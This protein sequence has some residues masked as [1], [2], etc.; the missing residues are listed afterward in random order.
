MICSKNRCRGR[1]WLVQQWGVP[2]VEALQLQKPIASLM[3]EMGP[4]LGDL[5]WKEST[6]P[7]TE[8]RALPEEALSLLD[9]NQGCHEAQGA[10]MVWSAGTGMSS[11]VCRQSAGYEQEGT[12]AAV[13]NVQDWAQREAMQRKMGDSP[14]SGG[15]RR[16]GHHSTDV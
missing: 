13:W 4:Q 16:I 11:A 2:Q 1:A 12:R 15:R 10:W 8:S 14:A 7:G 5:H 9:G 6:G 3:R